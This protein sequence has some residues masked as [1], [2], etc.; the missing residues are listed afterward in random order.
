MR[1]H[2][3]TSLAMLALGGLIAF[4]SPALAVDDKKPAPAEKKTTAEDIA[5]LEQAVGLSAEQK[6]KV[7]ALL[8]E[9]NTK[10]RAVRGDSTLSSEDKKAKT[11]A[12]DTEVLGKIKEAMT[13]EQFAKWEKLQEARRKARAEGE[14]KK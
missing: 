11:K 8:T 14:K 10:R 7:A 3:R 13:A 5:K 12:G 1:T 6:S 2:T 4:G 9:L